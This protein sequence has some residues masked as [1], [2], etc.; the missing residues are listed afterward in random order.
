MIENS[1]LTD[2]QIEE[3]AERAATKAVQK[4]TDH[5]YK[6]VGKSVLSKLAYLL[7]AFLV[8][9]SIWLQMKGFIK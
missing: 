5:I 1:P 2:A 9:A 8:G 6:S 7:G 3:I 4:M